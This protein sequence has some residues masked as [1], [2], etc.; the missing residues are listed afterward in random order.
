MNKP[1][2]KSPDDL[3]AAVCDALGNHPED[4]TGTLQS[5]SDAM[6]WLADTFQAIIDATNSDRLPAVSL[7]VIERW[8]RHGRY[9]AE[10]FSS[11]IDAQHEA[12]QRAMDK[13]GIKHGGDHE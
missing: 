12:M 13:A 11:T 6:S 7:D 9:L 10:D 2:T 5:S 3:V 4:I 1:I 8:A